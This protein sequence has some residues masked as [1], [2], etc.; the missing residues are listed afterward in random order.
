ML[1]STGDIQIP[2]L[3]FDY[4]API[5][6]SFLDS[7]HSFDKAI[8]FIICIAYRSINRRS[9]NPY[10]TLWQGYLRWQNVIT[11]P[12]RSRWEFTSKKSRILQIGEHFPVHSGNYAPPRTVYL[13]LTALPARMDRRRALEVSQDVSRMRGEGCRRC[14]MRQVWDTNTIVPEKARNGMEHS[15]KLFSNP[16]PDFTH[17]KTSIMHHTQRRYR[18]QQYLPAFFCPSFGGLLSL[19]NDVS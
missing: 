6:A 5:Q 19:A 11:W 13:I 15:R 12:L 8:N 16:F 2:S 7:I 10:Q 3:P 4:Y 17:T 1:P 14:Q 18:Q 9:Q